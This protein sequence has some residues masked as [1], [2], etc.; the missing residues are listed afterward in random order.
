M[1]STKRINT[2]KAERGDQ[3]GTI[4]GQLG[5]DDA[6]NQISGRKFQQGGNLK[7]GRHFGKPFRRNRFMQSES[8]EVRFKDGFE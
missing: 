5:L 2:S 8:K 4:S 1:E 3:F 6:A 7:H